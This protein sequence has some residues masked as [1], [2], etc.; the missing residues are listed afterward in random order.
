MLELQAYLIVLLLDVQVLL[1]LAYALLLVLLDGLANLL[2]FG[3]LLLILFDQIVVEGG[4]GL[5]VMLGL[6]YFGRHLGTIALVLL[7]NAQYF[8]VV[9]LVLLGQ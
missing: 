7:F 5:Q 4:V 6:L 2:Q 3:I 1:V 9:L 8:L